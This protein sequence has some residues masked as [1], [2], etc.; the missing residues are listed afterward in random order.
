MSIPVPQAAESI[1]ALTRLK[2]N[3]ALRGRSGGTWG[4]VAI[5]DSGSPITVIDLKIL[6][7][8][9]ERPTGEFF[10]GVGGGV[11]VPAGNTIYQ[12]YLKTGVSPERLTRV[13]AS[14]NPLPEA[15]I[16]LGIDWLQA[17]DP[18]I[19]WSTGVI[20][21]AGSAEAPK[22]ARSLAQVRKPTEKLK[23]GLVVM[24]ILAISRSL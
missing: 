1:M 10:P 24:L 9:R 6:T 3:C 17:A 11:V 12:L 8:M 22:P 14:L 5:I 21:P 19:D 16:L 20:S 7:G 2:T 18:D 13:Y 15:Q 23:I 4:G